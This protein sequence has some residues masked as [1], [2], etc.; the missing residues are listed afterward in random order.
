MFLF[1][2]DDVLNLYLYFLIKLKST[3]NCDFK[4]IHLYF[5]GNQH[6]NIIFKHRYN[7]KLNYQLII[8]NGFVNLSIYK[9]NDFMKNVLFLK[10]CHP[11]DSSTMDMF[12]ITPFMIYLLSEYYSS[13]KIVYFIDSETINYLT[14]KELFY[15]NIKGWYKNIKKKILI[16]LRN[17]FC[18]H[19]FI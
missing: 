19:N 4:S 8:Y 12:K 3:P 16:S 13:K 15:Q 10:L 2:V 18:I 14:K 17:N 6:A 1:T 9:K 11:M 5:L 7:E